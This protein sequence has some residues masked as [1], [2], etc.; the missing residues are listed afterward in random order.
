MTA[1]VVG[2]RSRK[3]KEE[4]KRAA[5][6]KKEKILLAVCGVVL[7]GLVALEGPKTLKKLHGSSGAAPAAVTPSPSAGATGSQTASSAATAAD[8]EATKHLASKDPFVTQLGTS[9]GCPGGG[10]CHGAGRPRVAL[11]EEGPVHPAADVRRP[12]CLE[13]R[14]RADHTDANPGSTTVKAAGGKTEDGSGTT[15]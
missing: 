6:A 14:A 9:R 10:S 7:V 12:D 5:K 4:A 1:G 3:R 13:R 8:L 15:S 2:F 11:R